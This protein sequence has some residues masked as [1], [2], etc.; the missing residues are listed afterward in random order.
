MT[1][2]IAQGAGSLR[3]RR[4]YGL[5]IAMPDITLLQMFDEV[6]QSALRV[7]A[8]ADETMARWKPPGLQNTILWHA[9]HCYVVVEHLTLEPLRRTPQC[10]AGW[11][12]LFGWDS[13]PGEV[14]AEQ[15]P[16][17][18]VVVLELRAQ[19]ARL[20]ELLASIPDAEL[21]ARAADESGR[22]VRQVIL[23]GF[24]DEASHK[25]E[26]WLLSKLYRQQP[27]RDES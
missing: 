26:M 24:Q 8:N 27:T 18:A 2:L 17:L 12:E 20:S 10:P 15:W 4:C 9:G 14:A 16:T 25:G 11:F 22:T 5:T 13:R 21:S 19:H 1:F 6:R 23:H 7:L 3:F